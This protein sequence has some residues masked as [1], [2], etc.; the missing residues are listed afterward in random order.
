M[1]VLYKVGISKI[2]AQEKLDLPIN[3]ARTAFKGNRSDFAQGRR[4]VR[5][6]CSQEQA[7]VV[8]ET[9]ADNST[10]LA[11]MR[12]NDCMTRKGDKTEGANSWCRN[13]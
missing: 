10:E 5:R 3:I 1:K 12:S 4:L 9:Q 11:N 8:Q 6:S 2:S 7:K 13:D